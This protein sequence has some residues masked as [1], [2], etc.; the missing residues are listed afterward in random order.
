ALAQ[1]AP[2]VLLLDDLHWIDGASLDLVRYLGRSW[3]RH[4]S[5]VLLLGT[6]RSEG[7]EPKSQLSAQLADLGRDLP[8]TQV[9]L[10]TLSQ[11]ETLQLL[12]AIV[13][14]EE[15]ST[16]TGGE[17]RKYGLVR[18]APGARHDPGAPGAAH[19]GRAPVGAGQCRAGDP[20]DCRAPVAGGRGGGAGRRGGAGGGRRQWPSTRGERGGRPTWP[21]SLRA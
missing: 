18:P 4:G 6:M 12:E 1:R 13:G 10:Q 20:G 9:S 21:L 3:I 19:A 11:A 17:Q 14:K 8:V 5:R 16:K 15:Q 2:L 7:L